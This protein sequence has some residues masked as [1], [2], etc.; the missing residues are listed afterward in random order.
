MMSSVLCICFLKH[1][2]YEGNK[3]LKF[4]TTCQEA[5]LKLDASQDYSRY[6]SKHQKVTNSQLPKH[7]MVTNLQLPKHQTVTSLQ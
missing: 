5:K 3:Y 6:L 2:S 1:N 7:Q 4:S